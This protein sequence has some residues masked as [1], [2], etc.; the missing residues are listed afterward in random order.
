VSSTTLPDTIFDCNVVASWAKLFTP[1][2]IPG[3]PFYRDMTQ[4]EDT[5]LSAPPLDKYPVPIQ[6]LAGQN[7]SV[8]ELTV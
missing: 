5:A 8:F 7:V 3:L 1:L 6:C 2:A 4:A